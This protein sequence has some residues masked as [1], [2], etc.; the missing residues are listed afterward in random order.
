MPEMEPKQIQRELEQGKLRPVYWLFGGEAMIARELL[1]RIRKAVLGE[2]SLF[3]EEVL[4]GQETDAATILDAA[5]SLSL[6][7]GLRFILVREAHH[8]KEAEILA[9]LLEVPPG[10]P[11]DP[12]FSMTSVCVFLAK[13]LDKRKKF[14]K[15]I[16]EKAAA[17]ACREVD[18]KDREAWIQYLAKRKSV[19]LPPEL[20]SQLRS[21][22]PWSLDIIDREL[23]KYSLSGG[24]AAVVLGSLGSS[25][26]SDEF[27]EAFFN[28]DLKSALE[29]ASGFADRPDESLP[30]LGLFSWNVRYLAMVL[31]DRKEGSRNTRL[32]P[33][34]A[35]RFTRW[36]RKWTLEEALRLQSSLAELDFGTKQTARLPLGL[37]STLLM[38]FG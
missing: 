6:G 24:D 4:D 23:E 1:G 19:E 35:D 7:G 14:S 5:Q 34:L 22:D 32:S 33:F 38:Q 21:L 8:V 20:V 26:G 16:L 29:I 18:E 11:S 10:S 15:L 12:N 37:W 9:P 36:S 3:N 27:F 13:D 17:V 2:G 25:K 31:A 28:R 30:L